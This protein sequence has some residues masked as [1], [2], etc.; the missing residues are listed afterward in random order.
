M[1]FVIFFLIFNLIIIYNYKKISDI[2]NIYDHPDQ[3]RK[4][5]SKKTSLIGGTIIYVNFLIYFLFVIFLQ[6]NFLNYKNFIFFTES[7]FYNLFLVSTIIFLIGLYDDKKNLNANFKFLIFLIL[8]YFLL[9]FES[10]LVI[11]YIYFGSIDYSIFMHDFSIFFTT[12]CF[13]LF[14]N[15]CNMFDGMDL[16]LGPYFIFI[17]FI[18][19]FKLELHLLSLVFLISLSSFCFLNFNSKVF[20]GNSGAYF[21]SFL[22]AYLF[23][24]QNNLIMKISVEEIFL[25]MSIP[26]I[27]MF[28]VFL[29]RLIKKKNPF[30]GDREHFHHYLLQTYN[31]RKSQFFLLLI[32]ATPFIIYQIYESISVLLFTF[33]FYFIIYFCLISKKDK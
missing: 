32:N 27:D 19:F 31:L 12:L 14:I 17:F 4:V 29:H 1:I 2:L 5:H 33:V 7:S 11:Q 24:A 9:T 20:I 10:D 13:L 22:I 16:Q 25:I 8:I 18:F 15:A 21:I 30:S 28:R 3:K 23:I 26:G 6:D